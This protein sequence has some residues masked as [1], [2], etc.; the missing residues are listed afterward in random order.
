MTEELNS[1]W[2]KTASTIYK[3]P[4]DSKI[5]G[6]VDIDITDL[7]KYI[8]EKRKTGLKLTLTHF[9]T[10]VVA[11][12]VKREVP[13][14]NTFVKRGSIVAHPTVD[15]S[16]SVLLDGGE[17]SS[18]RIMDAGNMNLAE[19]I[20]AIKTEIAKARK[21]NE[22]K[23]MRNKYLLGGIPWPLRTWVYAV[24]KKLL[25][26]WGFSFPKV[27]L[28]ANNFGAFVVS[29]IGSLGL[30]VG[31]PALLPSSNVSFVINLGGVIKKPWV[32]ND[33][34]LPRSII[35]LSAAFDHRLVDAS[36]IGTLFKFIKRMVKNPQ[37]ME[38]V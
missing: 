19:I 33:E 34:I 25:I 20:E 11:R 28:S 9:F 38:E 22:N 27:G 12:A 35:T 8:T 18:V 23:T 4:T 24:I 29:N 16:V 2:R 10:L 37:L 21:G 32:V 15:V 26:D 6:S 36:Q 3:K 31:Y 7:E 14:L 1:P 5:F 17:M 30:E 13:Q